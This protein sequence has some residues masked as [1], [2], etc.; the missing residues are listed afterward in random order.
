MIY[1]LQISKECRYFYVQHVPADLDLLP[2]CMRAFALT[3]GAE[4]AHTCAYPHHF[5]G[6]F[7][8]PGCRGLKIGELVQIHLLYCHHFSFHRPIFRHQ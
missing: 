8:Q 2:T 5:T 7:K 6:T 3:F 1:K 4:T